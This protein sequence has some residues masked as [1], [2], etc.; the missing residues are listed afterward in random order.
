MASTRKSSSAERA[1]G[2]VAAAERLLRAIDLRGRTVA[3]GFSGGVDST[4]LLHVLSTLAPRFGFALRA[5]HV[6][7]GISPNADDWSRF[8]GRICRRLD[9]PLETRRVSVG[10]SRG[11]GMEQAARQARRAALGKTRADSIA[12]AH[13]LDDQAETVLLNLLRGAGL[14]GASGMPAV[15]RLGAKLLLRPLLEVPRAEL[16]RYA[17]DKGLQWIEDESNQNAALARNFLRLRVTPLIEQRYPRWREALARAARHFGEADALLAKK[18]SRAGSADRLRLAQLRDAPLPEARVLLRE[19]LAARGLRPPTARRLA[20]MLRQLTLAAPGARVELSHDG[21]VV[22]TYRGELRIEGR[23]A[24]PV[25]F[26]PVQWTGQRR[27]VLAALGGEIRF[28]RVRGAGLALAKLEGGPLRLHLRNGGER[29]QPDPRRPRRTLKNLFQE[30]GIPAWRR[31]RLPLLSCGED[32]VWVPGLGIDA[33]YRAG[34]G[35]PGLAP[36]WVPSGDATH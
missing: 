10:S 4:V 28:R 14:R 9:V 26:G 23:P 19:Y 1:A 5:V 27:I 21:A 34:A 16:L 35:A 3:A 31:D 13:H 15:G 29:L 32:L 36:E 2:P 12:L 7:H 25:A 18:F 24:A 11:R 22:R 6:N 33:R 17:R 8:C 20:E 30:A